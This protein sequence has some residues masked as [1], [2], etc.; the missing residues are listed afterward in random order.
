M[1]QVSHNQINKIYLKKRDLKILA[2]HG[3]LFL[4]TKKNERV[5]S[6]RVRPITCVSFAKNVLGIKN[7]FILTPDQLFKEL[8]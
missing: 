3:W 5:F 7:P 1:F 8:K 2:N 6:L 4:K